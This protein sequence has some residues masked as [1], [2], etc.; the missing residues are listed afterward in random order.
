[1]WYRAVHPLARTAGLAAAVALAD[2]DVPAGGR[3]T[4][5]RPGRRRRLWPAQRPRPVALDRPHRDEGPPLRLHPAAES[6]VGA[7]PC[8]SGITDRGRLSRPAVAPPRKR[9]PPAPHDPPPAPTGH[10]RT[11]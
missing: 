9:L 2:P 11:G 6:D 8:R 4:H 10:R 7:R 1:M 3:R 5:R